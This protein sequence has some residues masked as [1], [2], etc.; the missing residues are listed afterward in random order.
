MVRII[1]RKAVTDRFSMVNKNVEQHV[2]R[3][4]TDMF[5]IRSLSQT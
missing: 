4:K 2:E 5:R 1:A 3:P